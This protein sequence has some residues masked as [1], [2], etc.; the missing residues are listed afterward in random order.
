MPWAHGAFVL[1][2]RS[3]FERAGGFDERQWMYAEDIEI[4]WRL[5]AA[6]YDFRYEPAAR[7]HHAGS[8]AALQAFG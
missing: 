4:A 8:A 6:G 5:H 3:A 1:F 7:V 2:R